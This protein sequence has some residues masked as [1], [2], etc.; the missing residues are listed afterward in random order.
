M[1]PLM[2]SRQV[3]ADIATQ[4]S[5]AI[6]SGMLGTIGVTA[7]V[8]LL[9][10]RSLALVAAIVAFTPVAVNGMFNPGYPLLALALGAAIIA[11]FVLVI[12]RD[13]LLASDRRADHALR[14]APRRR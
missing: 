12:L 2:G 9:K 1:R 10:R 7:A 14:P 6:S 3:L 11:I 13:G 8:L 5:N 4:V